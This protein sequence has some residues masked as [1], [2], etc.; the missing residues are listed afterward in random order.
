MRRKSKD[1]YKGIFH[2]VRALPKGKWESIGSLELWQQ[3]GELYDGLNYGTDTSGYVLVP[4]LR[5][6]PTPCVII[7]A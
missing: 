7:R 1:G 3:D 5:I 2:I 4:D 6:G